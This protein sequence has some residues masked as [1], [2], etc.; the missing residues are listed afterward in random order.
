M[1]RKIEEIPRCIKSTKLPVL[2]KNKKGI[3]T[4]VSFDTIYY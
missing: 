1:F 4:Y 3:V 2:M